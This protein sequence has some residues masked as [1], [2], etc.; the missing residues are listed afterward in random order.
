[1]DWPNSSPFAVISLRFQDVDVG[2]RVRC[3]TTAPGHGTKMQV[4]YWRKLD[5]INEFTREDWI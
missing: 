2:F 5:G 4:L 3:C 1:M